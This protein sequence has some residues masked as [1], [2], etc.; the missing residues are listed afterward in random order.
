MRYVVDIDGTI[1]SITNG[2]YDKAKPNKVRIRKVNELYHRGYHITYF[3]ARGTATGIDWTEI[4]KNQL[5]KWGCLYHKLILGKP[6]GDIFID[7]KAINAKE[8]FK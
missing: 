3:T 4:T 7:D 8:F 2:K 6:E 5:R 1:C